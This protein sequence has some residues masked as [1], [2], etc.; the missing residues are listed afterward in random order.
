M[1]LLLLFA[2]EQGIDFRK[3]SVLY[4][5]YKLQFTP[6]LDATTLSHWLQ[7]PCVWIRTSFFRMLQINKQTLSN[8]QHWKAI[9]A[10][11]SKYKIMKKNTEKNKY[12]KMESAR[13]SFI[14]FVCTRYASYTHVTSNN[15]CSKFDYKLDS[16]TLHKWMGKGPRT[17]GQLVWVLMKFQCHL[18]EFYETMETTAAV[19]S[20]QRKWKTT[21]TVTYLLSSWNLLAEQYSTFYVKELT[22]IDVALKWISQY[23]QK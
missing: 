20:W 17:S 7:S 21:T 19:R 6:R 16:Y 2:L 18:Q 5:E 22:E 14:K 1:A 13:L 10:C 12:G 15:S 3:I 4:A 9:N 11:L 8:R 23:M